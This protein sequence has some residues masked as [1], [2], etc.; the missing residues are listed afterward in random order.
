VWGF[1]KEHPPARLL[2]PTGLKMMA[3]STQIDT[4]YADFIHE[5][6][7]WEGVWAL[8]HNG[9]L[10]QTTA[11]GEKYCPIFATR[12]E[13]QSFAAS[14]QSDH[15]PSAITLVE[16]TESV[17]MQ[18]RAEEVMAGICPTPAKPAIVVTLDQLSDDIM[19]ALKD[20]MDE[21]FGTQS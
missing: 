11:S 18:W 19:A 9:W 5:V 6:A 14:I 7:E 2:E 15:V 12:E 16:L 3:S 8:Y 20:V 10:L 17:M 1:I 13:A 21:R 4:R